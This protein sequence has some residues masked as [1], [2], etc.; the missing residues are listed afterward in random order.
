MNQKFCIFILLIFI[1][2]NFVYSFDIDELLGE[3]SFIRKLRNDLGSFKSEV[4]FK[5]DNQKVHSVSELYNFKTRSGI[6]NHDI[7]GTN[8]T[9]GWLND[10]EEFYLMN[11]LSLL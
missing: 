6:L 1:I 10:F 11:S 3:K 2:Q 4:I 8:F 9:L 5:D 7:D